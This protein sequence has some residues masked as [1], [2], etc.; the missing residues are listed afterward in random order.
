MISSKEID[1]EWVGN[2]FLTYITQE[3]DLGELRIEL[4]SRER[5]EQLPRLHA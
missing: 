4:L 5:D 3:T 1:K 2:E